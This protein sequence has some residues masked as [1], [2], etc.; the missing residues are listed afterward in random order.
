MLVIG[1]GRKQLNLAP[2]VQFNEA[3]HEYYKSGKSLSG[4][5]GKIS[6]HLGLN[7]GG[8]AVGEYCESGSYLHSWIQDWIN[9]GELKS[10]HP[11]ATFI[12]SA[13][14]NKYKDES[15]YVCYS[16]V[17]VTDGKG[18]S[19]AVD[20]MVVRP[21]GSL[22]LY[23]IKS[24]A[25]K[26]EYLSFQLGCYAY[27]CSLAG[28]KVNSCACIAAKDHLIYRIKPRGKEDIERLLYNK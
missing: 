25:V 13:L 14:K 17:L 2:G 16:E 1:K 18:I 3:K 24:N 22:D 27:F 12:V 8:A 10:V 11:D 6:S 19:S 15:K 23:D 20:V 9:S 21:D 4:V 7:Y 26:P 5:T 28:Y